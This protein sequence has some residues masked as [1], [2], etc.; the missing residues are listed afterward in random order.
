MRVLLLG[1][2]GSGKTTV[3]RA[4]SD[5]TGWPYVDNDDLVAEV[6]GAETAELGARSAATLHAVERDVVERILG[7]EPP[8][9]AGIPG[10]AITDESTCDAMRAHGAV[11]WLRAR[12][13]TLASRI[14]DGSDRP[15]FAGR[16]VTE[17]LRELYAGRAPAY[18]AVAHLV[19][20]VDERT[21][22]QIAEWIVGNLGALATPPGAH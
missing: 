20:D 11:V 21:P 6:T 22:A 12:V 18:E 5:R 14:G 4:L 19:V 15:F 10:S 7:M 3:G 2:M 1:M 16:D 13:E 17:V 8:L 9:V